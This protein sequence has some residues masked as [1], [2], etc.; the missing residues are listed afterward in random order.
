LPR[1]K[2]APGTAVDRRN[3]TRADLGFV[4]GQRF[5][6]PE[7]LSEVA[8]R[9]WDAYWD[10][11]VSR[12][13]TVTDRGLL[14]RWISNVDRYWRLIGEAD[15]EP[16]TSNSQGR[17]ANPLYAVALK[18]EASVKSDEAQLGIGPKNRASL[19]IAVISE[20]RSLADMNA[21]Y[22]APEVTTGADTDPRLQAVEG[23]VV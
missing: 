8:V 3:G 15:G 20:R 21:R 11:P 13:H 22:V 17:V 4:A 1:T 10:D 23:R 18:I 5:D 9:Q 7:G 16:M 12:V 14:T 19:G 2:K 6:P